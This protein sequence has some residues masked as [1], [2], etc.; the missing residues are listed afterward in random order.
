MRGT[1]AAAGIACALMLMAPSIARAQGLGY[2]VK[3]GVN[4]GDLH[5]DTSGETASFD[6]RP[7]FVIGGFVTWPLGGRLDLQAE[8]LFTQ[9][10]AKSDQLG[11]TST[12]KL[13]YVE[14]PV[15]LSNRLTGSRE[16]NFSVFGGPSFGVRLRAR[17]SASFSGGS[18]FEE[19]VSDQVKRTDL[20]IV[21]GLAY[22]RGRLIVD[23]RYSWGLTDIDEE[24]GDDTK[25]MNRGIAVLAGWKFR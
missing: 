18:T 5:E 25:I 19:D 17:S 6:F 12:Q 22:H 4:L 24:T 21:G 23:G 13:D 9:K 15:L 8:G 2:G 7:G 16:R 1:A 11:G 14:I 20:A 3:G 10:G